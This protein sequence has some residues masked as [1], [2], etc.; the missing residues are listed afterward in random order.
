MADSNTVH[1]ASNSPEHIAYRL[2]EHVASVERKSFF[3][4][5]AE[6]FEP[7]T[8]DW[9]LDTYAECLEATKNARTFR[10]NR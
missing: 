5:A 10:R 3:A 1:I 9:I 4:N 6:R 7:A 8:R 2:L